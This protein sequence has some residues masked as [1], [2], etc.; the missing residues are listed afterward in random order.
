MP[1]SKLTQFLLLPKL[2][3]VEF[4]NIT[5]NKVVIFHCETNSTSDFCPHCGLETSRIHDHRV[6]T[7]IDAP[8]AAKKKILKIK[9]QKPKIKVQ[10]LQLIKTKRKQKQ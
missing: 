8:H 2:R 5:R 3:L 9:I 10:G 6:V 4:G 1:H 7:I